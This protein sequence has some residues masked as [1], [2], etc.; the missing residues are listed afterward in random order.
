MDKITKRRADAKKVPKAPKSAK[1]LEREVFESELGKRAKDFFN[2]LDSLHGKEYCDAYLAAAKHVLPSLK[3]VEYK[4]KS[5]SEDELIKRLNE[6]RLKE[7]DIN[8]N[9]AHDGV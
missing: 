5:E 3:S 4:D 1:K 8:K 7:E 2:T 6:L 9:A